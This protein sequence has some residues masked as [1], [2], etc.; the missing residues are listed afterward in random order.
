MAKYDTFEES[1]LVLSNDDTR[2]KF[3]IN[4]FQQ[5]ES[6]AEIEKKRAAY[7]DCELSIW[8]S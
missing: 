3:V 7:V 6:G 1:C 4:S 8:T 5:L 2:A